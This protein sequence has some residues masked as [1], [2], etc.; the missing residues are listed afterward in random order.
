MPK[1]E[2]V[3]E[4]PQ[5]VQEAVAESKPAKKTAGKKVIKEN[6][7]LKRISKLIDG[8]GLSEQIEEIVEK[9]VTSEGISKPTVFVTFKEPK[10]NIGEFLYEHFLQDI[11][12]SF[13]MFEVLEPTEGEDD[14][15][16]AFFEFDENEE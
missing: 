2:P 1:R 3:A 5:E 12:G 15:L 11:S 16:L 13:L 6:I 7:L 4:E 10:K 14:A 8:Y 9:R